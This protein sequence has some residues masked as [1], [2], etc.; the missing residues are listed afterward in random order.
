MRPRV[1]EF[2]GTSKVGEALNTGGEKPQNG[3]ENG[4]VKHGR[5]HALAR[6]KSA[7]GR[8]FRRQLSRFCFRRRTSDETGNGKHSTAIRPLRFGFE[9]LRADVDG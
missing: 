3:T 1:E 4:P 7:V 2:G 5:H 9:P 8:L 6:M